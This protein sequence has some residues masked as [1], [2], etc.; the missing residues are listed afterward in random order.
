MPFSNK[1]RH[2]K[3]SGR[4]YITF[5]ESGSGCVITRLYVSLPFYSLQ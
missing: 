4:N 1:S 5:F 2:K 3:L